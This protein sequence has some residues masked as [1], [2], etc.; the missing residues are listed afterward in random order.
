MKIIRNDIDFASDNS[1]VKAIALKLLQAVPEHTDNL[2]R[3]LS[4]D[5]IVEIYERCVGRQITAMDVRPLYTL[6]TWIHDDEDGFWT[7]WYYCQGLE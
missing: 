6:I 7:D 1:M 3:D 5:V 4:E 2:K